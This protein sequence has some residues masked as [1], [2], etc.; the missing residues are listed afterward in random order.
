MPEMHIAVAG[1]R[2]QTV[3]RSAEK[4]V[5]AETDGDARAQA[6]A[7]NR[8]AAR[9]TTDQGHK[10]LRERMGHTIVEIGG[11]LCT[12]IAIGFGVHAFFG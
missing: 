2:P 3:R 11:G 8:L 5:H 7:I 10:H 6:A 9:D 12:G 4:G 1:R